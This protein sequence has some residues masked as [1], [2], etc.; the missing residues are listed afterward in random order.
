MILD[1]YTHLEQIR[2]TFPIQTASKFYPEWWKNLPATFQRDQEGT[3][4]TQCGSLTVNTFFIY[5]I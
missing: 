2:S 3:S 4:S 1:C 5:Q